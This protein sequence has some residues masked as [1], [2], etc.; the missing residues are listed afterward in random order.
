MAVF[1]ILQYITGTLISSLYYMNTCYLSYI[2]PIFHIQ[3]L[4]YRFHCALTSRYFL[5]FLFSPTLVTD[6]NFV[7]PLLFVTF[8]S[9]LFTRFYNTINISVN[10]NIVLLG[11]MCCVFFI[12]VADDF[13]ASLSCV[14]GM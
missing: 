2:S 3:I 8:P 10:E 14:C 6:N 11:S 4:K 1:L 12:Y 7:V 13:E 5:Q 9:Q